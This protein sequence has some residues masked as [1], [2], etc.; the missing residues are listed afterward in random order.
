MSRLLELFTTTISLIFIFAGMFF[1]HLSYVE[2]RRIF[3]SIHYILIGCLLFVVGS[4]I[5]TATVCL[6]ANRKLDY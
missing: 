2:I 5:L 6:L 4:L 3:L 1:I